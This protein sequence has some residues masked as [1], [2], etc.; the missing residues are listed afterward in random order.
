M[1]VTYASEGKNIQATPDGRLACSPV[2]DSCGPMQGTDLDGPTSMLKSAALLPHSKG[3][4]TM[5]LNLRV[6]PEMVREPQLREKFKHL[7]QSYFAMGGLQVQVTVMDAETL[8]KAL[9]HPEEYGNLVIRIGGYTEYFNR[10]SK[11]LQLEVV[12]R[13]ENGM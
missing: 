3:L 9:E 10:L 11:E 13:S 7:L 2:A 8:K 1:F 6:R 5:V 12:K 4:G